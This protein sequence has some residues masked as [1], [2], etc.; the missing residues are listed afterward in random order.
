MLRQLVKIFFLMSVS[1]SSFFF[2]ESVIP[3]KPLLIILLG[4]PGSGKGTQAS[5]LAQKFGLVHISTG[6]MFRY[7]IRSKT[8]IGQKAQ[9]Y[10]KEGKLAPD[11]LV[12]DMIEERLQQ[13]DCRNGAILDGFPR[14]LSQADALEPLI[15]EAYLPIVFSLNVTDQTVIE[16][17][18][19]RRYCPECNSL[20]HT[21][22][23]PPQKPNICD[24]CGAALAIRNDDIEET[25]RVRLADFHKEIGPIKAYYREKG[26]LHEVDSNQHA[27]VVSEICISTVQE[28]Q[29]KESK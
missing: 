10:I 15:K 29:Q 22:F 18:T 21:S 1:M 12:I 13:P 17:L 28:E 6:D 23:S 11:E 8:P 25:I 19:G 7:H 20:Y 24:K 14:T 16:R 4:A 3:P 9:S 5:L 27:E 26:L 2:G